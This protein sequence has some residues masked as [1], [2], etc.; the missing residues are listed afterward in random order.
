M[1]NDAALVL[2]REINPSKIE[3]FQNLGFTF[4]LKSKDLYCVRLPKGW[5]TTS[6]TILDEKRR[7]RAFSSNKKVELLHRYDISYKRVANDRFSP[8]LVYVSDSDGEVVQTM[9]LCGKY[10]SE[11]FNQLVENGYKY[12]NENFPNWKSPYAYWD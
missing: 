6:S 9:G 10:N 1:S 12:L 7:K 11:E 8:I 2:P 3:S 5:S 4:N